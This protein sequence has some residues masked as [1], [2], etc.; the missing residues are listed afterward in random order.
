MS[1]PQRHEV[2][3]AARAHAEMTFAD[4]WMAY[5]ALGGAA[6]PDALRAYLAGTETPIIDYDVIVH[7]INERFVEAGGNHPVPYAEDLA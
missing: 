3:E 2:L 1:A 5:F 7:A 6:A 4:L